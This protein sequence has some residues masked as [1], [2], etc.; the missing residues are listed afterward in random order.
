VQRFWE[1]AILPVAEAMDARVTCEV[2][3][4]EGALTARL[5]AYCEQV[6]GVVHV[7][8][9]DPSYDPDVWRARHGKQFVFHRGISLDV[10]DELHDVELLLID[11]DHNWHT[12]LSEL[13]TV[14]RGVAP[15]VVAVH[16]VGWPYG[17]R[18]LYHNPDVIPPN[19]R[20]PYARRGI[21]PEVA[22][23]TDLGINSWLANTERE[24]GPRNGV[25]TAVEDFI[26]GSSRDWRL[27]V[28]EGLSGLA[29]L[30]PPERLTPS[31]QKALDRF[32][33]CEFLLE[34]IRVL[35]RARIDAQL[36]RPLLTRLRRLGRRLPL[37]TRLG[38]GPGS[39]L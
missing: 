12:V 22:G 9:P 8:D 34:H 23:L 18:D 7:I 37:R 38:T 14:D 17:R 31:V 21:H 28:V 15:P 20:Q 10:L 35:E 27:V 19:R 33:S 13:Q 6:G 4:F 5:V 26:A 11:G 30:T 36:S 16:D 24:G 29:V 3:S 1:H 39:Q 25:M 2:G 32:D